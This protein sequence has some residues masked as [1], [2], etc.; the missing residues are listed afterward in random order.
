MS[1]HQA[2]RRQ[3]VPQQFAQ[4]HTAIS[5]PSPTRGLTLSDNAAFM[6]PGGAL[7]LDNWVPTLRGVKLR[8]G[9]IRW[10]V[11][12]E[13]TPIISGMEF[14]SGVAHRMFA[15]NATKLY[16]V[17]NGGT[18]VL[19]K[20]GQTSGN[21]ASAQLANASG[22]NLIVVNDGGDPVLRFNGLTWETLD[23]GQI[24]ADPVKYPDAAVADGGLLVHV[25]KYRSRLF[26]IE[27][28]SM[29]A[30]YLP[31]N[32]I[33]G[34]LNQIPLS[35]AATRGGKLL[36]AA[37]WGID[38]GDG[39]DDK[40]VFCTDLGELLIFTGGDPGNAAN[41]RQEGR[42]QTDPPLG[43]NAHATLG[44]DLLIA[45]LD[46]L[47]PVSAT[48]T[49]EAEQL[50][51]VKVTYQIRSMWRAEAID[52]REWAWSMKRWDEYGGL[53]VTWPGGKPGQ[54]RCAVVNTA[55]NAWCR[56]TGWDATCFMRMRNDLFFGT[57]NGIVMQADRTGYDDGKPYVCT[58][59]GHWGTLQS[60]P[61]TVVWHQARASFSA[62]Q[63]G[64]Q[65]QLSSCTDFSIALP[66]PPPV[67][68][69]PGITDVWDQ[70]LW[71]QG[72][73]DTGVNAQPIV[74]NSGWVSI[75]ITGFTHAVVV[76]TTVAQQ[77]RPQIEMIAVDA[78]FERL[79]VNV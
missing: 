12:P 27:Q 28:N 16:D 19:V 52:K 78:T 6:K 45:T 38:A 13:N 53:F 49:K 67:G 8:G 33:E 54:E 46:G 23:A 44:G 79:G 58:Y 71:D 68:P 70:A 59:V 42:Y 50:D 4:K 41:W 25:C 65:P 77:A 30:W 14:T 9:C 21:Y 15:A 18:P 51:L 72:K 57:Q 26:F 20:D 74:R 48:I 2:F 24:Y 39:L 69:D 1:I 11:L 47:V 10:C 66:P 22:D 36:F 37:T 17:T 64:F 75:G 61:S 76:Q 35:G 40:L 34:E 55:T 32:A 31:L 62:A 73:W 5:I 43:M 56:F 60:Q 29:N 63:G 7:V 3:P